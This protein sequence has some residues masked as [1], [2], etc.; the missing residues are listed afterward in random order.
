MG[1]AVDLSNIWPKSLT[2]AGLFAITR[3]IA[4]NRIFATA[5]QWRQR[6]ISR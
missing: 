6:Q 2:F 4:H 5:Y 1:E 3:A